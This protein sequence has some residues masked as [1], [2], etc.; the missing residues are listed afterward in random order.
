VDP[1]YIY[2]WFLFFKYFFSLFH[3]LST[4]E[5]SG[6]K[7]LRGKFYLE[8]SLSTPG[9]FLF[10]E[11]FKSFGENFILRKVQALRG[12]F[13]LEKSGILLQIKIIIHFM[14]T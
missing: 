10:G 8:K 4:F 14:Q 5:K 1:F 7:A 2:Y 13:Y 3:F 6:A 12:S 9:R 11:K